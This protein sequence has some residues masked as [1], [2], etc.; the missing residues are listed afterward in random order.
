MDVIKMTWKVKGTGDEVKEVWEDFY[1]DLWFVTELPDESGIAF[2]YARLYSM[3]EFAE[4]GSFSWPEILEATKG[5]VWKV[6][7]A[8]WSNIETYEK[9]LLVEV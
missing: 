7:K 2:G 8:N 1:G 6:T 9:G 4:W 3:P 5:K